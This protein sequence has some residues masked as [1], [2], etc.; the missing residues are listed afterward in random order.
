[1]AVILEIVRNKQG[2]TLVELMVIISILGAVTGLLYAYY[3][4]GYRLFNK[5]FKFGLLQRNARVA[6]E[7]L[8]ERIKHASRDYIF[9]DDGYSPGVP[10]PEDAILDKP[11]I[12]FAVPNISFDIDATKSAPKPIGN[13][14]A[15]SDSPW[16]SLDT[17]V[18][19][20]FK[21]QKSGLEMKSEQGVLNPGAQFSTIN[22]YDYY[23]Y[24]FAKPKVDVD[25]GPDPQL[26]K[27]AKLKMLVYK[28]QST[29]YTESQAVD[30]PFM[31]PELVEADTPDDKNIY[32]RSYV[33]YVKREE[34]LI[35]EFSLYKST[36]IFDYSGSTYDRL[37]VIKVNLYDEGSDTRVSFETAVAPRN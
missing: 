28:N 23:L 32:K 15:A 29:Q 19:N 34:D 27:S 5:S 33:G 25:R 9:T 17:T 24:Y 14:P 6:L 35:P 8:A 11:Y 20:P 12:Y 18:I 31:P 16:R 36:V 13:K 4:D 30:W 26:S 7:D 22:S 2:H 1:M 37:F 10:F 3:N 21:K